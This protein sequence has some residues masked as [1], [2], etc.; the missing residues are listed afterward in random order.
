MPQT[1][2]TDQQHRAIL[3]GIAERAMLERGLLPTF[4]AKA[5][6]EL[7]SIHAPAAPSDAS[8]ADAPAVGA[9]SAVQSSDIYRAR[10]RNRAQLT[11]GGVAAWLDGCAAIPRAIAAV[12]GL[13]ANL[14]DQ[15]RV[16][17]RLK[18]LRPDPRAIDVG[19]RRTGFID[20][21]RVDSARP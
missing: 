12:N 14:H 4:S 9:D 3:Q 8:G 21:R 20:F 1:P 13:A 5:S 15:D 19:Q 16:A 2:H 10:V 17:Q 11:Y 18:T 6:A 7:Q